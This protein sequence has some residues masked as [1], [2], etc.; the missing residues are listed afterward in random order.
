MTWQLILL[1]MLLQLSEGKILV[2]P[3]SEAK[4]SRNVRILNQV[5]SAPK[6]AEDEGEGCVSQ[7]LLEWVKNIL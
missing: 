7:E 6:T 4:K 5:E 3:F 2:R 1:V